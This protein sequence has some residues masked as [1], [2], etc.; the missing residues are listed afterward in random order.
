VSLGSFLIV[1]FMVH[2]TTEGLGIVAPIA[3]DSPTLGTLALAG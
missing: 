3:K 2:N 1:G